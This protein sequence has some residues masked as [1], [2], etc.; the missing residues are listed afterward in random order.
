MDA[1]AST[2]AA[3]ELDADRA[4]DIGG[5]TL[6]V[7]RR[8]LESG[9]DDEVSRAFAAALDVVRHRGASIVDVELPHV[10][11]AVAVYYIIATAEASSNLARYDGVRY[12]LRSDVSASVG[13]MYTQTRGIGFGREVKRRLLLGTYVLSAGYYEAHYRRAQQVRRLIA[14]DH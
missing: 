7:P 4:G 13:D 10:E 9:V 1:T 2:R 5:V 12:G 3:S 6:G 11:H 8:L 14:R